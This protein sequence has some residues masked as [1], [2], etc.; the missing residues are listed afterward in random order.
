M[1]HPGEVTVKPVRFER[2]QQYPVIFRL[3]G[4]KI[5]IENKILAL[6]YR[7]KN[8][9]DLVGQEIISETIYNSIKQNKIPN[10]YLFHGIRGTG[11]TS[12]ARIIAKALNC[13]NGIDNLC[14]EQFCENCKAIS[15]SSHLDVIEQDC[16]TATGIDSVRDLIEFCRYP[17]T[18]G[19]Y[20]V[21]I[22]DEIQAMSKA[23]A[24]SLLKIL[25]EPPGYV[26]FIFCTTEIKKILVTMLSRCTRFDLLRVDMNM[27]FEHLKKISKFENKNISDD[28]LKLICKC[29]EGSVRDALS[30][31]DRAFLISDNGKGINLDIVQKLFGIFDKSEIV[32]LIEALLKGD[33]NETL[34]IYKTL[35]QNGLEPK[36]FLNEFLE[37]LYYFKNINSI[38]L[39]NNNLYLNEEQQKKVKRLSNL[40]DNRSILIFWE[41]TIKALDELNLV[42]NQR[43]SIEIF[44]IR[45]LHLRK[46][47]KYEKK[48]LN[49]ENIKVDVNE[50]K[51]NDINIV[52]QIKN[53]KQEEELKF[54]QDINH[55]KNDLNQIKSFDQ[56]IDLCL[57]KGEMDLKYELET[58]VNLVS[59]EKNRI[60][61][62][63]NDNLKKDFIKILT[64]KLY[65]WTNERWFIS[66]TKKVG[67]KSI[68][69]MKKIKSTEELQKFKN[70]DNYKEINKLFQD[71]TNFNIEKIGD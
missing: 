31:L 9:N 35:N 61:I 46:I 62:S 8:L 10:A 63:F 52:N 1:G 18:V 69:D 13:E 40:I 14:K 68:K 37:I 57:K 33:E 15:S 65:D 58:N 41:V 47:E 64:S 60:E 27:L 53:I 45:L 28:A 49:L 19:K 56:L 12:I 2:K 42:S 16:A 24:Q 44:L 21:L 17:P 11:K 39:D 23:G 55:I 66:L 32:R 4:P 48:D 7:P 22:L 26:K 6:K 25:E 59:F 36:V 29:S 43:L 54:E 38:G 3:V 51:K 20:K 67:Y 50:I 70:S 71:A 5:M 30:L 34:K